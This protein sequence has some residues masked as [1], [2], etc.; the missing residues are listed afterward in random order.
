[1]SVVK[2]KGERNGL[3]I[4]VAKIEMIITDKKAQ[5]LRCNVSVN[6]KITDQVRRLCYLGSY[7]TE[8]GRSEEEIKKRIC[9]AIQTRQ[10]GV[11]TYVWAVLLYG[12][13]A[14]TVSKKMEKKLEAA[15][16]GC[17]RRLLKIS[18]TELQTNEGVSHRMEAGR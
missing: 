14:W 12:S 11:K 6:D 15:E 5:P 13:E 16:M 9:D 17:W 18:W 7:I 4:K 8:D 3:R 2:D 10:R 1:M